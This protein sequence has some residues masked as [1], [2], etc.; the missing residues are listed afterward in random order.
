MLNTG[1]KNVTIELI[2][3]KL[4]EHS[5]TYEI[6]QNTN[7]LPNYKFASIKNIISEGIYFFEDTSILKNYTIQNSILIVSEPV[8]TT[9]NLII[10]SNPQLVHY[11]I[12][13]AINTEKLVGIS[14]TAKIDAQAIIAP[15]VYIGENCVI[16]KCTIESDVVIKHNVVIEDNVII[17]KNTFIDS[18][19]VIGA[20]GLAWI[21]DANGKRIIQPQL[22]GV[23]IE[24]NCILGT[25]ITVVRG[26]LSENTSI[27]TGTVIAHG[28]KIG[29]GAI[30]KK[31]VHIANNVSIAGNGN[32][33]ERCFLGSACVISS[34]VVVADNCI[35]GAGAVVAKNVDENFVTLAGVPAKIIKKNNFEGKPKGA[36]RPFKE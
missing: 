34:N 19:S 7:W 18:N 12:N 30:I 11:L 32:V 24:E 8:E 13:E 35:V 26:S 36:P 5:V 15:N 3:N 17:K 14:P 16:G 23:I 28:T 33:G 22:G 27:G 31:Y 25:D 21:W 1:G 4:E 29:H 20:G 9:N 10:I 2:I 6:V